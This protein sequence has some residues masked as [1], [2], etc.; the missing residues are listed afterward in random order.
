MK[1]NSTVLISIVAVIIVAI[2]SFLFIQNNSIKLEGNLEQIRV[3]CV[4]DSIT[5]GYGIKNRKRNSY[6]SK[7]ALLLGDNWQVENFGISGATL[8]K[9]GDFSYWQQK[10]YKNALSF[11]P[12]VVVIILGSNDSKPQ[13]WQYKEEYVNDYIELIK[14]FQQL[15]SQPKIWISYP[16]PSYTQDNLSIRNQVIT[17][18]IIPRIEQ[19]ASQTQV[20]IIDLYTPLS[21][22]PELFPDTVH[23]NAEGAEIIAKTVF[24]SLN[25]ENSLQ[26]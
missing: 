18:E 11:E 9:K 24:E 22:K 17:E 20:N 23:P 15:P 3:A 1:I 7:L 6:P 4:G 26:Q 12:D 5:F 14:S 13:N 8:L 19:I 2:F 25:R 10:V 16:V 21:N